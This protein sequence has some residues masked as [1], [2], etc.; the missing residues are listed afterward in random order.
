MEEFKK[1]SPQEL[2]EIADMRVQR[3]A[4]DQEQAIAELEAGMREL[5]VTGEDID[6]QKE[7]VRKQR[8]RKPDTEI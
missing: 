5:G 4:Q 2:K 3:R 7:A 1:Q 8:L 6:A